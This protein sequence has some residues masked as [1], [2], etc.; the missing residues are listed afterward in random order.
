VKPPSTN[1]ANPSGS[2]AVAVAD[3]SQEPKHSTTPPVRRTSPT[4][5]SP[6]TQPKPPRPPPD[7]VAAPPK[8]DPP[9]PRS[10]GDSGTCDEISCVLNNNE[11]PCCAKFAKKNAGKTSG[12]TASAKTDLP[13]RLDRGMIAEGI[14]KV[15]GQVMSCGDKSPAKGTVK[16]SVKVGPDGRVIDV[17]VKETPDPGLGNCVKG[18]VQKAT[19]AKTQAGGS[20][21]YP[22]PF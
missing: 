2:N 14:G 11:G 6:P 17:N 20:F 19:F 13:E 15:R 21:A 1:P 16:V 5:T 7:R 10:G 18:Q 4:G 12:G 3:P 9:P 8:T 22:Y